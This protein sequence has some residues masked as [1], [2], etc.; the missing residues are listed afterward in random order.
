MSVASVCLLQRWML[1]RARQAC[2][3]AQVL[4]PF[5]EGVFGYKASPERDVLQSSFC[6]KFA[7]LQSTDREGGIW[8]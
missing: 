8:I 3:E 1:R 4:P 2:H 7:Q 5:W 6:G